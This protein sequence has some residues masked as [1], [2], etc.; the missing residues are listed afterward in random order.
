MEKGQNINPI[1]EINWSENGFSGLLQI[2]ISGKSH[3]KFSA[4][5][6]VDNLYK[7]YIETFFLIEKICIKGNPRKRAFNVPS[8]G[9]KGYEE[10]FVVKIVLFEAI[11]I[12]KDHVHILLRHKFIRIL[13]LFFVTLMNL[14]PFLKVWINMDMTYLK[15]GYLLECNP[16][17]FPNINL[18]TANYA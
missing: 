10:N 6:Q 5:P 3:G 12:T 1:S 7:K 16:W 2:Q 17:I 4:R 13:L 18:K 11:E 8:C 9:Y 14:K 15:L